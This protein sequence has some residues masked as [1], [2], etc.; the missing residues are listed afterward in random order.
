MT[1]EEIV[2]QDIKNFV[3]QLPE[4]FKSKT[5]EAIQDIKNIIYKNPEGSKIAIAYIGA[6]LAADKFNEED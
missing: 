1:S 2:Y 4:P 3:R 5:F 6:K